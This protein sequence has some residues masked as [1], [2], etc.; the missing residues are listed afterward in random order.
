MFV[1]L[2]KY[3]FIK[4]LR[5]IDNEFA[6]FVHHCTGG[7]ILHLLVLHQEEVTAINNHIVTGQPGA[8]LTIYS[9]VTCVHRNESAGGVRP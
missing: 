5:R 9:V 8:W 1:D 6:V 4:F 3:I 2:A 7:C